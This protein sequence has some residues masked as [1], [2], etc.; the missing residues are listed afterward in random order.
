MLAYTCYG[1]ENE[2]PPLLIAHGLFGS[3][4]N[5]RTIARMLANERHVIC[6]DMRN[7][8]QSPWSESHN[9]LA[10]AQDLADIIT[11]ITT[12]KRADVLGHSM[13]GKA[14]MVLAL[15]NTALVE[16]LIVVDIAPVVYQHDLIK[17]IEAMKNLPQ[18]VLGDRQQA[19]NALAA[20]VK[21][22]S[23]RAFLLQSLDT[24]QKN[25]QLNLMSLGEN[26]ENIYDFPQLN[27]SFTKPTLFIAGEKSDYVQPLHN[28]S[29]KNVYPNAQIMHIKGAGH[30]VHADQ[31]TLFIDC[32]GRFLN[33]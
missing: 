27:A 11:A 3:M 28:Q 21:N 17:Y 25:W 20:T 33:G 10:L 18:S 32:V 12:H 1:T 9:Y 2:K 14:A 26:L 19:D 5:W 16:R 30:W 31:P 29:I 22:P 4:R 6:V 7:H 15:T 23:V 13:G 24:K 8:G